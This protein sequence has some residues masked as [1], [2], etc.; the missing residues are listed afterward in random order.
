M[1]FASLSLPLAL[2]AVVYFINHR[3][4]GTPL[5]NVRGQPYVHELVYALNFVSFFFLY[6]STFNLLEVGSHRVC[7]LCTHLAVHFCLPHSR[8]MIKQKHKPCAINSIL[9]MDQAVN[10]ETAETR[11]FTRAS[12]AQKELMTASFGMLLIRSCGRV[13]A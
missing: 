9:R 7:D 6:P 8:H 3:Y 4:D 13:A 1:L 10:Y 2:L 11:V 5:W 12:T